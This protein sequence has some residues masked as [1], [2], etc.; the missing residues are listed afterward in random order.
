MKTEVYDNISMVLDKHLKSFTVYLCQIK[1]Y[2][3]NLKQ[4]FSYYQNIKIWV[5]NIIM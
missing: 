2:K 1:R 3:N 5:Q 4:F